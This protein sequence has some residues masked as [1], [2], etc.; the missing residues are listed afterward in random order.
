MKL[1][2]FKLTNNDEIVC[3]VIDV[4]ETDNHNGDIIARKIL[5]IFHAEDFDQNVRYYSFKPWVAFQEDIN[6]ISAINPDHIL[7]EATPSA[8]LK[9][10]FKNAL[11]IIL[12]SQTMSGSRDL[13]IDEVMMDT[14]DMSRDEIVEY[15]KEKFH[16]EN[17]RIAHHDSASSN[18]IHLYPPSDKLH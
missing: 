17:Q 14:S 2:Q 1:R 11:D 10:H 18:V 15:L 8:I 4:D 5:K 13:N 12:Q 16:D 3:E 7:G 6:E 9:L